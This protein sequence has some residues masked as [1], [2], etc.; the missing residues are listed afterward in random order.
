MSSAC[1]FD[2]T[3]GSPKAPERIAA[4]SDESMSSAPSG[5]LTPSF[6]N[7]SALQSKC[8]NSNSTPCVS[9]RR[10]STTSATSITSGPMPSPGTTAILFRA[11]VILRCSSCSERYAE[12]GHARAAQNLLGRRAEE[13]LF[14]AGRAAAHAH[15]DHRQI[16]VAR[17]LE[18]L[19]E[20]A[21]D[22]DHALYSD[23]AHFEPFERG[24]E[25]RLGLRAHARRDLLGRAHPGRDGVVHEV[26]VDDVQQRQVAA[27]LR[28]AERHAHG[29][30]GCLG[31]VYGDEYV[32]S[33]QHGRPPQQEGKGEGG[34]GK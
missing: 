31:K 24:V 20:G 27:R 7:L 30:D 22:D 8:L 14:G 5:K 2:G 23:V 10:S 19:D 17:D 18:Y 11:S 33:F 13:Q 6:R 3:R 34:K 28:D 26:L 25:V 9:P 32:R 12:H 21:A 1:W 15:H 16:E 4:N 29:V